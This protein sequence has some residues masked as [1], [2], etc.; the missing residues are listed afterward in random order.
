QVAEIDQR[1]TDPS[2]VSDAAPQLQS[3]VVAGPSIVQFPQSLLNPAHGVEIQCDAAL[4]CQSTSNLQPLLQIPQAFLSLLEF[5][6]S[7]A[8]RFKSRG[9][10]FGVAQL[11]CQ[12]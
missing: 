8:N 1:T 3:F 9:F 12:S 2:L 4:V 6:L 11:D 5:L 10:T 7:E